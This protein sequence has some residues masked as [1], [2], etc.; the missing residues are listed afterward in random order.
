MCLKPRKIYRDGRRA[1]DNYNGKK[2]EYYNIECFAKCG[3]CSQCMNEKSNN[4]VIRAYHESKMH[5]KMCFI[6]L[7]YKYNTHFLIKEDVQKFM[8]RL[9]RYLEYH[10]KVKIRAFING[11]YGTLKHRPHYHIII[12]GWKEQDEKLLYKGIN[13]KGNVILESETI[14]KLWNL[15]ITSY[16]PFDIHEIPY[17]TLYETARDTES[18]Q[19]KTTHEQLAKW[20]KEIKEK[21]LNKIKSKE[22]KAHRR[23]LV[24]NIEKYMRIMEKNKAE[25]LIIRE[26][27]LWS[28]ALGWEHFYK[29]YKK[30]TN[31]DWKEYIEDK[32][33]VTPSP[34]IKKLANMGDKSAIAEMQ[35]RTALLSSISITE[36]EERK[37]NIIK[38][39]YMHKDKMLKHTFTVYEEL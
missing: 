1:K 29:E 21:P 23:K 14:K 25:Y 31:Y 16:Q 10:Y 6:T 5:V 36:E 15:G 19:Y 17:I 24:K 8:K 27:N 37:K 34:W 12:Y 30:C 33:F 11:E 39:V 18:Y 32:E 20:L 28:K 4:W 35:R 22:E 7:T 9:R 26:F 13:K 38:N 3:Y 2:G